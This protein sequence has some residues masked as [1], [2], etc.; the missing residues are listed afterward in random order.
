MSPAIQHHTMQTQQQ[1]SKQS[2][3]QLQPV[4]P[5]TSPPDAPPPVP[6]KPIVIRADLTHNQVPNNSH[7]SLQL[8]HYHPSQLQQQQQEHT[9]PPP[10]SPVLPPK[11]PQ[12]HRAFPSPQ[13]YPPTSYDCWRQSHPSVTGSPAPAR[14]FRRFGG[15]PEYLEHPCQQQQQQPPQA[16][17][18][19]HYYHPHLIHLQTPGQH[20]HIG[21]MLSPRAPPSGRMQPPPYYPPPYYAQPA[22]Q[23]D[24]IPPQP[25]LPTIPSHHHHHYLQPVHPPCS[26]DPRLM[27][28]SHHA[29][30]APAP[31]SPSTSSASGASGASKFNRLI[32][33]WQ[34]NRVEPTAKAHKASHRLSMPTPQTQ[35]EFDRMQRSSVI[36]PVPAAAVAPEQPSHPPAPPHSPFLRHQSALLSPS[37]SRPAATGSPRLSSW[38]PGL[39]HFKQPK[40]CSIDCI[41]RDEHEA[42]GKITQVLEEVRSFLPRVAESPLDSA[43]FFLSNFLLVHGRSHPGAA[44]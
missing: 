12:Q 35:L 42:V 5:E 44:R 31:S 29:P 27:R 8:Q 3:G 20:T 37:L 2:I 1:S 28:H 11:T 43:F 34:R 9:P 18:P 30:P 23:L 13:L 38:L 6:P 33:L 14:P 40:V 26:P 25:P 17:P 36:S 39:F 41:A 24:P 7:Y 22:M 21:H 19:H 15:F 10:P 32:H 16:Y 4:T